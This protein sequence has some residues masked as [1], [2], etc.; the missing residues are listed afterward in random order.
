MYEIKAYSTIIFKTE[1]IS[2]QHKIGAK[3]LLSV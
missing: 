2:M 3:I 1:K